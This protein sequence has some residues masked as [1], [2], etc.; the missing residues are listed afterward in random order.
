MRRLHSFGHVA[1][2]Y[3]RRLPQSLSA[4]VADVLQPARALAFAAD[5]QLDGIAFY[6]MILVENQRA[7][8]ATVLSSAVLRAPYDFDT[9]RSL[10][11]LLAEEQLVLENGVTQKNVL[12]V[13]GPRIATLR[14]L[15]QLSDNVLVRSWTEAQYLAS[16]FGHPRHNIT[17]APARDPD[18]PAARPSDKKRDSIVVWAA[19]MTSATVGVIAFALEEFVAPVIIVSS[20]GAPLPL[21]AAFVTPDRGLE[22]LSTAAIIID[23]SLADPGTGIALVEHG[24]PVATASTSG[25]HEF[26]H[27]FYAYDPWDITSI[28]STASQA[29]AAGAQELRNVLP[30]VVEPRSE[31]AVVSNPPLVSIVTPTYNRRSRLPATLKRWQRQTYPNFEMILVNDGGEAVDDL[32]KEFSFVRVFSLETNQGIPFALN[33]GVREAQ[34]KYLLLSADDDEFAPSHIANLVAAME[35]TSAQAAHTNVLVRHEEVTENGSHLTYGYS[36]NWNNSMDK[37]AVLAT[38][39]I[40][41]TGMMMTKAAFESIGRY[42]T[43]LPSLRDYDMILSLAER[44]DFAHVDKVTAV[45]SY[46]SDPS[47]YSFK[48]RNVTLS[49]AL[50]GIYAKHP[51]DRQNVLKARDTEISHYRDHDERPLFEPA[52]RLD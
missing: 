11:R 35:R 9:R 28:S 25:A 15:Y 32:A 4:V 21:K 18:V 14:H 20:D 33:R 24:V 40:G 31:N 37:T 51:T 13:E 48:D 29:L 8:T 42:D 3:A 41:V 10:F 46:R 1:D 6:T 17:I 34:G 12:T 44:Y 26:L 16:L 50:L 30:T 36:L 39:V 22:A 27:P 45:Y 23:A 38:G 19:T 7:A 52:M 49:D 5:L 47:S 2:S 43:N